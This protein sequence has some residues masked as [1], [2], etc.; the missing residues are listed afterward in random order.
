MGLGGLHLYV[1]RRLGG[2]HYSLNGAQ[3]AV[4]QGKLD[5]AQ[6]YI[7]SMRPHGRVFRERTRPSD[8]KK[9]KLVPY[10]LDLYFRGQATLHAVSHR[11]ATVASGERLG[12]RHIPA[13]TN[14]V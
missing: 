14:L 8:L 5:V 6:T 2:T 13:S 9:P 4:K 3:G 1:I 10:I 11:G 7:P 12:N